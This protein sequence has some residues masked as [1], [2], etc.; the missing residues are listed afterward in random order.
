MKEIILLQLELKLEMRYP[1]ERRYLP[2]KS[3]LGW[4]GLI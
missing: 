2:L 4:G 3:T 1:W